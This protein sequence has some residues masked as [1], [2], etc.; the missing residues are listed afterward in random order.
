MFG[1][2]SIDFSYA[3]WIPWNVPNLWIPRKIK[4]VCGC[5]IFVCGPFM[6]EITMK[7]CNV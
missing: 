4:A 5:H 6:L 7:R 2:K 1:V 3:K